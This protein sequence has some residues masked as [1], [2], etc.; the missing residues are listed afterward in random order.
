MSKFLNGSR[1]IFTYQWIIHSGYES[2]SLL[3]LNAS[4]EETVSDFFSGLCHDPWN[5]NDLCPFAFD[6]WNLN[7]NAV[8]LGQERKVTSN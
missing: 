1:K 5:E 6:L 8:G 7:G 4:G 3:T 2:N